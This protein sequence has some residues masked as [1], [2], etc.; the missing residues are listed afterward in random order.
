MKRGAKIV[1]IK[2]KLKVRSLIDSRCYVIA[3]QKGLQLLD[4]LLSKP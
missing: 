2:G 3:E 4:Q 1:S